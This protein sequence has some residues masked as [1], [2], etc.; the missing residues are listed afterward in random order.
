[1]SSIEAGGEGRSVRLGMWKEALERI[2]VDK[3][4]A[5]R[6]DFASVA[7]AGLALE[8][9]RDAR[10]KTRDETSEELFSWGIFLFRENLMWVSRILRGMHDKFW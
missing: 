9:L 4:R 7:H 2:V 5:G 8:N 1:V 10:D 3:Q 6:R